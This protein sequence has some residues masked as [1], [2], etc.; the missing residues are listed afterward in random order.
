MPGVVALEL[1]RAPLG[2]VDVAL[3]RAEGV[4]AVLAGDP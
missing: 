2:F 3:R 1:G 4:R